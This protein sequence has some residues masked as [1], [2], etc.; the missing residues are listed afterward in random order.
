MKLENK[1]K[2][3]ASRLGFVLCGITAPQVPEPDILVYKNWLEN[4]R[5]A[6]M[7][8]LATERAVECRLDIAQLMPDIQSILMVGLAYL[9]AAHSEPYSG[10]IAGYAQYDDYHETIPPRLQALLAFIQSQTPQPVSARWYTDTG[11]ILERSLAQQAGVG[12]IGKNSC[13][14]SPVAGSYFLLGELMVDIPLQPD[15]PFNTD[16]CGSCTRC[17]QACPT[18][19]ILPDRTID[20][21]RCISYLTIENKAEIPRDLRSKMGNWIFG[22]D[23]CQQ[24]CPWNHREN[25]LARPP[26]YSTNLLS[27]FKLSVQEFNKKF[28]NTPILRAKRRG[29]LR[30]VAVAIGNQQP[31]GADVALIDTL[32]H[33]PEPLVRMHA[34][35]ALAQLGTPTTRAEL[36]KA[37]ASETDPQVVSEI[38]RC[39]EELS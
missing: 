13:L 12:W 38:Q 25:N 30:N 10:Q 15:T 4:D 37:L 2:A 36:K 17:M 22:C 21:R 27:E 32:L 35:W 9:P 16:H 14:I 26:A 5:H 1:I 3:E 28:G 18:G 31:P 19:C 6:S 24:V 29:Y 20:S 34:A 23:I 7:Q 8:Y 11:P 39:L 33:E